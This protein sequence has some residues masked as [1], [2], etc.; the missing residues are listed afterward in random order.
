MVPDI[1]TAAKGLSSAYAPLSATILSDDIY[2][3][4]SKPQ[5]EGIIE[6]QE[7]LKQDGYWK[8]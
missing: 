6:T 1:I 4:I 5:C 3:V 2:D 7:S 8:P